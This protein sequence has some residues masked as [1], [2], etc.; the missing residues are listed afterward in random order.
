MH[1]PFDM[2]I[3]GTLMNIIGTLNKAICTFELENVF[4]SVDY[5]RTSFLI[6][7]RMEMSSYKVYL[8]FSSYGF[9]FDHIENK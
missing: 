4:K 6:G 9:Y 1:P 2:F 7:Y 8:M 5:F 3:V